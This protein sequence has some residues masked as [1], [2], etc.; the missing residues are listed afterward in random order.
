MSLIIVLLSDAR[1][2]ETVLIIPCHLSTFFLPI[3]HH[4]VD[5][6]SKWV[7][8]RKDQNL[9]ILYLCHPRCFTEVPFLAVSEAC[10]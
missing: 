2:I 5:A 10:V 3:W 9:N 8:V 4:V 6:L 7:F 1:A